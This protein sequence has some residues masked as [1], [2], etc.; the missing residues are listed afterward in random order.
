MNTAYKPLK[1]QKTLLS[2]LFFFFYPKLVYWDGFLF[3]LIQG[4]FGVASV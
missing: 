1:I 2:I 4:V 3:I